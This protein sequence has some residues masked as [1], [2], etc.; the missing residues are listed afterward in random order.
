[1]HT[2]TPHYDYPH[3]TIL[4]IYSSIT[5]QRLSPPKA[6]KMKLDS[7]DPTPGPVHDPVPEFLAQYQDEAYVHGW[8]KLWDLGDNLNWDTGFPNP[9]L[10]D[11]L[12]QH[13]HI[14]GGPIVSPDSS[15]HDN[16]EKRRKK[17][18]VPGCG[19][20]V[21]VLLLASFGYD[22]YGL[23]CGQS[24]VDACKA[25]HARA[26]AMNQYPV[27][28]AKIRSGSV[29]FVKG[30][31]F[32]DAW[33]EELGLGW[34]S[35][36]LIY[37]HSVGHILHILFSRPC[38]IILTCEVLLRSK[39][40]PPTKLGPPSN[41]A[42][43]RPPHLSRVSPTQRPVGTRS[44]IRVAVGGLLKLSHSCR[45]GGSRTRRLQTGPCP[46]GALAATTYACERD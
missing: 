3:G 4:R 42:P 21:D 18:L 20:G 39:P 17:A 13:H 6:R 14:L 27:R 10:E 12:T 8:S 11:T 26:S 38:I 5:N 16:G 29:T 2:D 41:P 15:D 22:A 34:N 37:D 36:D 43:R 45:G 9:A 32:Q 31:F 7:R 33:L 44:A 24:A 25:E 1:M 28:D 35:F 40:T 19:R 23:E 30:D 46:R